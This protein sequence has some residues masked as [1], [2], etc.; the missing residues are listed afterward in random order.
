[1]SD[2]QVNSGFR[3]YADH[4]QRTADL[5][6][7]AEIRRRGDRR[8]RNRA[9]GAAFAVVLIAAVGIGVGLDRGPDRSVP[10]IG[11][12]A[13]PSA[14]PSVAASRSKA[15]PSVTSNLS[16]LRRIGVD[17]NTGVLI[18]VA[19][20]GVDKWLQVGA[21][22]VVDFTGAV[23]DSSTEMSLL[24]AAT[25]TPNSVV[26]VPVALPDSCVTATPSAPLQ[27][28]PCQEGDEAQIWEIVPAGDSGQFELK[29]AFGIQRVDGR[30]GM[31]TINF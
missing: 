20:D 11:P 28:Q 8:R 10:P 7:A 29:G 31:Q 9:A 24:P 16:Q 17:L 22:D 26:I 23:K 13:S 2:D 25:T 30:T 6:P 1:M 15:V 3:A 27:L 18:D 12:S 21:G 14:S 19:D 5:A 4:L